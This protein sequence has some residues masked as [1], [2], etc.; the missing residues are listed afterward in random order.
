MLD[1][2]KFMIKIKSLGENFILTFMQD[3]INAAVLGWMN[4]FKEDQS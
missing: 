4:A 3:K 2:M 1:Y